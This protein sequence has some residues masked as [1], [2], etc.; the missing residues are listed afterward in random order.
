MELFTKYGID[1]GYDIYPADNFSLERSLAMTADL[2]S[3]EY[4][5]WQ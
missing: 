3:V 4:D 2:K 1:A 5:F